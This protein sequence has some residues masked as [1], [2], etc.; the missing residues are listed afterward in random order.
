[1]NQKYGLLNEIRVFFFSQKINV[2]IVLICIKK[3]R[4]YPV[5]IDK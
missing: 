4:N 1:M 2:K 5:K 3:R